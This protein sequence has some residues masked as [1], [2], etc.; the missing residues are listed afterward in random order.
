[1]LSELS[2]DFYLERELARG[3]ETIT[4]SLGWGCGLSPLLD[5]TH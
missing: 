3:R 1:M 2:V 4:G 5:S